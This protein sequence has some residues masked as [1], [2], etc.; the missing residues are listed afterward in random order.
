MLHKDYYGLYNLWDGVNLKYI[1][2]FYF[3]ILGS[4]VMYLNTW[5]WSAQPK[6]VAYINET[7]KLCYGW[8]Q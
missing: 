6:H 1:Y 3:G 7:N 8:W 2:A 4:R 5:L